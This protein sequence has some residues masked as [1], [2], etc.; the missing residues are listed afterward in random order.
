M[1]SVHGSNPGD[2]QTAHVAIDVDSCR[3]LRLTCDDAA[4]ATFDMGEYV[5]SLS[6]LSRTPYIVRENVQSGV[7][8]DAPRL[9]S[10]IRPFW[11]RC[12]VFTSEHCARRDHVALLHQAW[13]DR[14]VSITV[15]VSR[16]LPFRPPSSYGISNVS[17]IIQGQKDTP[18]NEHGRKEAA[19]VSRR[20]AKEPF[21]EIWSSSLSR[22]SEVRPALPSPSECEV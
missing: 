1:P 18:L 12:L 22:A 21:A 13:T 19:L 17:G 4:T 7:W 10:S 5:D 15:F 8:I 6:F 11:S 14:R 20:L 2:E 16:A 9:L 3:P